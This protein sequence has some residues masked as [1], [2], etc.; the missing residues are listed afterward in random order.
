MPKQRGKLTKERTLQKLVKEVSIM[1]RLQESPNVIRLVG[2]YE[3]DVEAMIV[4]ELCSGGDLQ[5]LSEV[6]VM[7]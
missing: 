5:K 6:S 1:Q 7:Q 4:C 3:T 2:C